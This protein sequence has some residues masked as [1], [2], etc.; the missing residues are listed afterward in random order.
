MS[1][2]QQ[3]WVCGKELFCAIYSDKNSQAA[4]CRNLTG[5][6]LRNAVRERP[7][8][9]AWGGLKEKAQGREKGF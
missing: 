5:A 2:I 1:K 8:S 9:R 3:E 6:A 7:D 4:Q